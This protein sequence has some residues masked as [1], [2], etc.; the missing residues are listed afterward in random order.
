MHFYNGAAIFV[1]NFFFYI[2]NRFMVSHD[3]I[4]LGRDIFIIVSQLCWKRL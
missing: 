2:I 3:G 4:I 1:R